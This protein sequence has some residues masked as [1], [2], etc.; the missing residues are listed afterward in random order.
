MA[1]AFVFSPSRYHYD[2]HCRRRHATT[3]PILPLSFSDIFIIYCISPLIF[4]PHYAAA[5]FDGHFELMPL[6]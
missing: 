6:D 2:F 1:F 4:S 3:L 5:I